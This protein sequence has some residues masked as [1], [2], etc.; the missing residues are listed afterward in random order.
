M[1]WRQERDDALQAVAFLTRLPIPAWVPYD[2]QTQHRL[3]GHLPLVGLGIGLFSAAIYGLAQSL[4]P[5]LLAVMISTIA[6][7]LL[8]GALH[9]D[10][11]ADCCD[12]IGGGWTVERRL[13]IMKDS[14]LGSY[15]AVGLFAALATKLATL[16]L[17]DPLQFLLAVIVAHSASRCAAVACMRHLHYVR[18]QENSKVHPI[19]QNLPSGT[20][21]R[22]W[23]STALITMVALP[24]AHA[25]GLFLGLW[26]LLKLCQHFFQK[27]L[28]GYTG[29][30][31]GAIQQLS[32]LSIY[33][34]LAALWI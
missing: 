20:W 33:L 30:V 21:H 4:W 25:L 9:E 23:V 18:L 29:D 31:L 11:L 28:G 10:G 34:Y 3:L 22:A 6:T 17:F 15:G 16:T 1:N 2:D 26:L 8:T 7:L 14:C 27:T 12:G 13:A 5:P 32:E 19:V 24:I